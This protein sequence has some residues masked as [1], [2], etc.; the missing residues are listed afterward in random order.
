MILEKGEK[1]DRKKG[2]KG[3][4]EVLYPINLDSTQDRG[5]L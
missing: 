5:L 3:K 4:T 1:Q 2:T